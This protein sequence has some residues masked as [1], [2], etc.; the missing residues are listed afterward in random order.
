MTTEEKDKLYELKYYID[1]LGKSHMGDPNDS[2]DF[3][4][5]QRIS[6]PE[7]GIIPR[8]IFLSPSVPKYEKDFQRFK[9]RDG[10][11]QSN[12]DEEPSNLSF[13]VPFLTDYAT[14]A[15]SRVSTVS[16]VSSAKSKQTIKPSNG[17]GIFS[18]RTIWTRNLFA[19][20]ID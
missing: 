5:E 2:Q 3:E 19:A 13:P 6:L 4:N 20:I 11:Y 14:S 7:N 15:H 18:N 9:E 12:I 16:A 10:Y 17:Q 8:T 1:K